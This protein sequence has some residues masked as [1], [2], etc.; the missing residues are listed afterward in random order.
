MVEA[1]QP[2]GFLRLWWD[3][4][5]EQEQSAHGGAAERWAALSPQEQLDRMQGVHDGRDA[6]WAGLSPQEKL[7]HMQGTRDHWAGLSSQE[8]H[9]HALRFPNQ[10]PDFVPR[11][12]TEADYL[13]ANRARTA[14]RNAEV[15]AAGRTCRLPDLP[16]RPPRKCSCL[17]PQDQFNEKAPRKLS[18]CELCCEVAAKLLADPPACRLLPKASDDAW[19]PTPKSLARAANNAANRL[20]K[21]GLASPFPRVYDLKGDFTPEATNNRNERR[22]KSKSAGA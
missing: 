4:L 20:E 6:W 7:D 22:A 19:Y 10:R 8:Q 21:K 14:E 16:G 12:A 1:W 18:T 15:K 11:Y 9:D 17:L 5:T 13:E 3:S 2:G